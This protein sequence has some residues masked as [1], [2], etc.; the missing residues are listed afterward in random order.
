MIEVTEARNRVLDALTPLGT[1]VVP[2]A[3]ALGRIL[4]EPLTAPFDLPRFDNSAMD[5]YAVRAADLIGATAESP[6]V[7]RQAAE[8]PAGEGAREVVERGCCVRL[9]TGS[10][11]PPGADAV[12]MQEDT[13]PGDQPG[14]VL[15][16]DGAKPWENVRLKGQDIRCGEVVS[17]AG[18]PVNVGRIA[19]L[20][21]C[22]YASV[23]VG[24]RPRVALLATGSELREPGQTLAE[25]Q[26]HETNRIALAALVA[27]WGGIPL[28]L[29]IV[30]D[31][32]AATCAALDAAFGAA[33]LVITSGGVS[34]GTRDY[35]KEAFSS[36]GGAIEFWKVSMRPGKPFV[37]GR[38]RDKFLFGLPGNPVSALSTF[39]ILVAP[40]LLRLQGAIRCDPVPEQWPLAEALNNH[41]DRV[42]FAR[43]SVGEEGVRLSGAQSSD[44]FKS[45]A[46]SDGLVEI[47]PRTVFPAGQIVKVRRWSPDS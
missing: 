4:R 14:L 5:G 26:I 19:L 3:S 7:L 10:A 25:G 45:L 20:G 47:P 32:L 44:A 37:F 8:L 2:L 21:A 9:F 35:V 38:W 46:Q 33:D 13:K 18:T 39:R 30:H 16:L 34:V 1:E 43:V 36:L 40:A 42:H 22:G 15:F 11:M 12:V 27:R 6:L 28:I 41:G 17:E 31:E 23:A 24:A 29:P